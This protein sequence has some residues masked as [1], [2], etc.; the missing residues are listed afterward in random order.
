MFMITVVIRP[1]W[2][3]RRPNLLGLRTDLGGGYAVSSVGIGPSGTI[4]STPITI[5]LKWVEDD[6]KVVDLSGQS[7]GELSISKNGV[8]FTDVCTKGYA[9]KNL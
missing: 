8:A 9:E 7:E 6:D 3:G 1:R 2:H 5:P 4:V